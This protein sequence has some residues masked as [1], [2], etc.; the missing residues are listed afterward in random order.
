MAALRLILLHLASTAFAFAA[1]EIRF[2]PA[3]TEGAVSLGIYD[4]GGRLVRVLC[5]EWPFDRF[6]IG[7]NGL[8]TSW[9]GSD[10]AGQPVP[11]GIYRARGYVVGTADV[12][13][14]AVWFNDWMGEVDA[15][16]IAAVAVAGILPG[17]DLLLA[18]HLSD[19]RGALL[20]YG[21]SG[22]TR[23][24][25]LASEPL[26]G[27]SG[28]ARLAV[29][30][31]RAFL[32]FSGRL[33]VLSLETGSE[34]PAALPVASPRDV[35]ACGDRVAVLDGEQ[36][37][38]F[39]A[40]GSAPQDDFA[41]PPPGANA[42]ALLSGGSVAAAGN[43]GSLWLH[44]RAWSRLES[45]QGVKVRSLASGHADTFWAAEEHA[46]GTVAVAQ[47]SPREG[48]LAEWIPPDQ[49]GAPSAL[50]ASAE[51]D[52]FVA[53]LDY[54]NRNRTVAI[55]RGAGGVWELAADKTIT[56]SSAYGWTAGG[57][58]PDSGELP[59]TITL[60][61]AA[62]PLDPSASRS[63]L[64]HVM[65]DETGTGLA[66]DDGLPLV[67]VSDR[68]G[69]LRVMVRPGATPSEARFYQGNGSCVEEYALS[70]LGSVASFDAGT[71]EMEGGAERPAPPAED[72][73]PGATP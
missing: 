53:V 71:I 29:G 27:R 49:G 37:K 67:R 48:C 36:V 30:A 20:R 2:V 1:V 11:A 17:G 51:A 62:N 45:A 3:A 54:A 15:P 23:W 9:D 59:A 13:G 35:S 44:D 31:D 58:S 25:V 8:A 50:G 41:A 66:A 56:D 16:A 7:L 21:L 57:L 63:L 28:A 40:N 61:L 52:Y 65:A 6:E 12:Q 39:E 24:S 47:Y 46:D 73:E 70:G 60:P 38:I 68:P 72:A 43:D 42:I 55:R 10:A 64:L 22:E 5:D 14:E 32:L 33:R 69:F 26:G 19:G 4:S 18:A 34:I